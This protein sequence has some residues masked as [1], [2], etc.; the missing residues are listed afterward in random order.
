MKDKKQKEEEEFNVD[1]MRNWVKKK[2]ARYMK[3]EDKIRLEK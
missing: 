3:K 1:K 2:K